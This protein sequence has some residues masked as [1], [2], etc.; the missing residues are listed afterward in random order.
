MELNHVPKKKKKK[1]KKKFVKSK[2]KTNQECK[3]L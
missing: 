3:Y 1:K 2:F